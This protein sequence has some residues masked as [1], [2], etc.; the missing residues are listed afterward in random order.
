MKLVENDIPL[1]ISCPVMKQNKEGLSDVF[2]LSDKLKV[3]VVTDYNIMA[4]YDNTTENLE[5]RLSVDEVGDV[6][7]SFEG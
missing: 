4:K 7:N 2:K 6:I 5:N 3:R 1:Q